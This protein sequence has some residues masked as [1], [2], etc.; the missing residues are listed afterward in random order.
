MTKLEGPACGATID[1]KYPEG[2][3]TCVL[4]VG[5]YVEA[6]QGAGAKSWHT[7]C[8]NVPG[9]MYPLEGHDHRHLGGMQPETCVTW[10]DAAE[11]ATPSGAVRPEEETK[12]TGRSVMDL[13]RYE[14]NM[15]IGGATMRAVGPAK[16]VANLVRGFADAFEEEAER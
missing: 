3:R 7:D 13:G 1:S 9:L 2:R 11:G 12:E 16:F 6:D 14:A 4:A 8:P 15:S 10:S 5:H